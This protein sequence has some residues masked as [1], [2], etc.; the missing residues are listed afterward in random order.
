MNDWR[1]ILAWKVLGFEVGARV[2]IKSNAM[3]LM[4]RDLRVGDEGIITR[5]FIWGSKVLPHK[6]AWYVKMHTESGIMFT[7]DIFQSDLE[8]V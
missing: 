1:Q 8:L 5:K 2:R 7:T 4:N 6:D 3:C